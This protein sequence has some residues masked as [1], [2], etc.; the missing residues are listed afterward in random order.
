MPSQQLAVE[1][2]NMLHSIMLVSLRSSD[3]WRLKSLITLSYFTTNCY[4]APS[5][6]MQIKTLKSSDHHDAAQE[7]ATS[8]VMR[9]IHWVGLNE[10]RTW[11]RNWRRKLEEGLNLK[12]FAWISMKLQEVFNRESQSNTGLEICNLSSSWT[13]VATQLTD[14]PPTRLSTYKN[15]WVFNI[16]STNALSSSSTCWANYSPTRSHIQKNHWSRFLLRWEKPLNLCA[17]QR[18]GGFY[19]DERCDELNKLWSSPRITED[20]TLAVSVRG[21]KKLLIFAFISLALPI[22]TFIAMALNSFSWP[23]CKQ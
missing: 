1:T 20:S 11:K 8:S 2:S 3:L 22:K 21:W 15:F 16:S 4:L 23:E 6:K 13:S 18:A 14:S 10:L 17:S 7:L 12:T 9:V 5:M 19:T